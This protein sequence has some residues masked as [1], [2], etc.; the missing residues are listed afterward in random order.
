MAKSSKGRTLIWVIV[1]VLVVVAVILLVTR[2]KNVGTGVRNIDATDIP[3]YVLRYNDHMEKFDR[4][5]QNA[6]DDYG[7][8]EVFGEIDGKVEYIR[9]GLSELEGLTEPDAIKAKM[10]SIDLAYKEARELLAAL[11]RE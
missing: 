10:D 4:R 3:G 6:L 9:A 8:H 7:S 11:K 5:V 1:G 2:P